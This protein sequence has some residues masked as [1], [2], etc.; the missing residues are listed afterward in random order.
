MLTNYVLALAGISTTLANPIAPAPES[1]SP[2]LAKN[3]TSTSTAPKLNAA[4]LPTTYICRRAGTTY[5]RDVVLANALA[6]PSGGNPGASGF[7]HHFNNNEG[8]IWDPASG[9]CD[10]S[11][12]IEMP[13]FRDGHV[14]NW[15]SGTSGPRENPGA[16]RAIYVSSGGYVALCGVISHYGDA[17]YFE[18]CYLV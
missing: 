9:I 4:A 5:S 18:K 11:R 15:N 17:G 16:A 7:P 6:F 8:F 13:I 3:L 14:Y 10:N 1:P 12:I 2:Q